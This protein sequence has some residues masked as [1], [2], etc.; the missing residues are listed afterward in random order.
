M[1]KRLKLCGGQHKP[2]SVYD[3]IGPQYRLTTLLLEQSGVGIRMLLN[4]RSAR[5]IDIKNVELGPR[6]SYALH[7]LE[8]LG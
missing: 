8:N 6:G 5:G 3:Y 4:I 1:V 2:T 7:A